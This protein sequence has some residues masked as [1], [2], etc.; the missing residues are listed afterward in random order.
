LIWA[1][2]ISPV[3]YIIDITIR[4]NVIEIPTCVTAPLEKSLTII[5]PV[6]AKTKE[7]VP[8]NSDRYL[9]IILSSVYIGFI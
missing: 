9:F 6:P 1:P 3:A 2:D 5:A 4:P 7:K 8:I